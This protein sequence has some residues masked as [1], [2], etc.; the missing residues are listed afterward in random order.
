MPLDETSADPSKPETLRQRLA[1]A[2][3]TKSNIPSVAGNG[4]RLE[5]L[6]GR[7]DTSNVQTGECYLS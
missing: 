7:R 5:Y 1:H 4:L 2:Q 3:S 6:R